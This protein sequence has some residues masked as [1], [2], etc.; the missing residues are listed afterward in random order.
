MNKG[1]AIAKRVQKDCGMRHPLDLS[2]DELVYGR[3]AIL[4]S[5]LIDGAQ[6]RIMIR[7][8]EAI[9]T[10]DKRIEQQAKRRFVI[11]HELGHYEMHRNLIEA[12]H[13]DPERNFCEWLATGRHEVEANQFAAE[14]LMP[15]V[16]FGP[17]VK[18]QFDLNLIKRV[19]DEFQTS[20]TA[21]LLN[22]RDQGSFSVAIVY[23]E[24][25]WIKWATCSEDFVMP[26]IPRNE[27]IPVNS[28]ANDL[29]GGSGRLPDRPEEID[30][31][32]WFS[33]DYRF[34]EFR[35]WK[36]REQCIQVAP[37]GVLSAIWGY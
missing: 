16:L 30:T 20:I 1:A 6:G 4:K 13:L 23:S 22:Y 11:A 15:S 9:I 34:K 33:H 24:N 32:T 29:F 17:A 10:Y 5:S 8:D 12:I 14:L 31:A 3:G 37:R 26:Y 7:G 27:K 36:F 28:V 19:A 25:G 2:L 18:G 21:T 35:N